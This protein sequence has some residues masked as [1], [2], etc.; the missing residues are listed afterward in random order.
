VAK[1]ISCPNSH[2]ATMAESVGWEHRQIGKI[3]ILR[4][5]TAWVMN[6]QRRAIIDTGSVRNDTGSHSKDRNKVAR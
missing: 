2:I 5:P 4:G 6:T 1:Y 3:L